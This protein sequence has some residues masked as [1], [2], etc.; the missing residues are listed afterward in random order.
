MRDGLTSR[1]YPPRLQLLTDPQLDIVALY[2][3]VEATLRSYTAV[4]SAELSSLVAEA[5]VALASNPSSSTSSSN[6]LLP[7]LANT[8]YTI[9]TSLEDAALPP[10]SDPAAK[11][12]AKAARSPWTAFCR[13]LWAKDVL[14]LDF[15][16]RFEYGFLARLRLTGA[17]ENVLTRRNTR[18][19]TVKL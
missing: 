19:S 16:D 13:D 1:L 3:V 5:V 15:Y 18:A 7:V 6:P 12:A 2:Q 4:P 17:D 10:S 14:P 8:I 9:D 11:V